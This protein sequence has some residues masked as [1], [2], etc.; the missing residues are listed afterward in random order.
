MVFHKGDAYTEDRLSSHLT[1]NERDER[2]DPLNQLRK[3]PGRC[4]DGVAGLLARV[5]R[6]LAILFVKKE[7]KL[8]ASEMPE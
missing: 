3:E 2:Y 6:C 8:S 1:R 5:G 7:A 4:G